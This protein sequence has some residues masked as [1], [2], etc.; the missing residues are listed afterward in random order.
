V[1]SIK[2]FSANQ[3]FS[4]DYTDKHW[5]NDLITTVERGGGNVMVWGCITASG[6][7]LLAVID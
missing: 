4:I 7:S 6:T 5:E 3:Q 2:N 1:Q